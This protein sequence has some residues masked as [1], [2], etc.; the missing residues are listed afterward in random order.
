MPATN[1]RHQLTEREQQIIDKYSRQH[2]EV[3]AVAETVADSDG[4]IGSPLLRTPLLMRLEH[5][6]VISR[7][8]AEAGERFA[9]LFRRAS[10]DSLK[11][12]DPARI[13]MPPGTVSRDLPA[14]AEHCRRLVSDAVRALG[15]GG[16]PLAGAAWNVI[17][18][19]Q[20]VRAWALATRRPHALATGILVGA[21]AALSAH[22]AGRSSR[23]RRA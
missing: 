6:G 3:V 21:L 18:L 7:S 14:S 16:S 20:S 23:Q 15:G 9:H 19:E 2:G 5:K 17:G 22:F 12:G 10:L 11:A 4:A 13:P 1:L 8:E